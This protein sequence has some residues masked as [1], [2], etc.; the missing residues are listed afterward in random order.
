MR[1]IYKYK[2]PLTDAF[3]LQL[4]EGAE[5]LS[6]AAQYDKPMLWALVDDEAPKE[7]HKFR[8]AEAWSSLPSDCTLKYLGTVIMLNNTFVYHV[9]EEV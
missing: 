5:I 2:I 7:V 4:P 8:G 3:E 6:V 1:T 9:F